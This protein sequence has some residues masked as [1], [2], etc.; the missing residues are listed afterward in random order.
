MAESKRHIYLYGEFNAGTILPIVTTLHDLDKEDR[1]KLEK[2]KDP[3]IEPITIHIASYG[4]QVTYLKAVLSA[5]NSVVAPIVTIVEG[6][7]YSCGSLLSVCGDY[8]I[9]APT[10]ELMIHPPV[11]GEI[12]EASYLKEAADHLEQT[13][14]WGI[15]VY[16][17]HSDIEREELEDAFRTHRQWYISPEKALALGLVDAIAPKKEAEYNKKKKTF[18]I[19]LDGLAYESTFA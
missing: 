16:E 11:G 12:G 4:G 19:K 8:R 7:A 9:I 1:E 3:K 6:A 14:T 5:M 18:S 2:E 10:G 13:D 15:D 17:K